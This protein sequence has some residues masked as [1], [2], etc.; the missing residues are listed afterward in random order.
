V[1]KSQYQCINIV[2]K[3]R[4]NTMSSL[5]PNFDMTV[6]SGIRCNRCG[7]ELPPHTVREHLDKDNAIHVCPHN[8]IEI[9]E[10]KI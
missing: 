10:R 6:I 1:I 5:D 3:G 8:L 9:K 2:E 4:K 7:E